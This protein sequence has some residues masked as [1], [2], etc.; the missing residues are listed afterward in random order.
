MD[1]EYRVV[2]APKRLK[3]VRGASNEEL[4]A[5]TITEAINAEARQ[6]WEYVGSETFAA[7][8]TRGLFRRTVLVEETVLVFRRSRVGPR[9]AGMP[10]EVA[11]EPALH[12]PEARAAEQRDP[13]QRGLERR[14][15]E[16][17]C[18][19]PRAPEPRAEPRAGWAPEP[20]AHRVAPPE[21]EAPRTREPET[22]RAR[23]PLGRVPNGEAGEAT[24]SLLRPVPRHRPGEQ[25]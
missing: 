24:P 25:G 13:E 11:P 2:P 14:G 17:R 10:H 21:A 20:R 1:F 19:E 16:Q 3:R 15:P 8:A 18:P 5:Q 22:G 6:G 12:A 23:A 9:I 4:C 7:E